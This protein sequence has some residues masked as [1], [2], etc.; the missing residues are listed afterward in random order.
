MKVELPDNLDAWEPADWDAFY[1]DLAD[2]NNEQEARIKA[3]EPKPAPAEGKLVCETPE[4]VWLP[5]QAPASP[6]EMEKY[7]GLPVLILDSLFSD[8][9]WIVDT[10]KA[11]DVTY[12]DTPYICAGGSCTR[13]HIK[14]HPQSVR[15]LQLEAE[16]KALTERIGQCEAHLYEAVQSL[17]PDTNVSLIQDIKTFLAPVAPKPEGGE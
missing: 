17:D 9:G 8:E 13:S 12:Y 4:P 11:I 1:R 16:N 5:A 7:V 3:L 10:L 2:S 15:L 14:P 6:D